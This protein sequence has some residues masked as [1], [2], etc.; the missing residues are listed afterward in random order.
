MEPLLLLD[1]L[2]AGVDQSRQH[3]GFEISILSR[4][5]ARAGSVAYYASSPLQYFVFSTNNILT[6]YTLVDNHA[7]SPDT[8]N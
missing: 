8:R 6:T 1:S 5:A 4:A 2:G 7:R 3:F